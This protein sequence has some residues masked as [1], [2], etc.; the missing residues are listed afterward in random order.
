MKRRLLTVA[1]CLLA[2]CGPNPKAP[3]KVMALAPNAVGQFVVTQVE[4]QTITDVTALKGQVASLVGGVSVVVD[5]N[6]PLQQI[7]GGFENQTDAQRYAGIV[8]NTG[9]DV[10]GNFIDKAGVLW[11]A[12][13]NTWDMVTTYYNFERSYLY[14][15]SVYD[16]ADPVELRGLRVMYWPEVRVNS[17]EPL[18]DNAQY[19]SYIKSFVV[20]PSEVLQAVPLSMNVGVIGHEM[21]HR[22]FSVKV[23]KDVGVPQALVLWNNQPFN[24]LKSIDE[25]FAD[26]H[27]FGVTCGEPADCQPNFLAASITNPASIAIRDMSRPDACLDL[28]LKGALTSY[29]SSQWV[30]D[31][32]LYKYGGLWAAAL[33]QA[34]FSAGKI[35]TLQK[36]LVASYNDEDPNKTGLRQLIDGNLNQPTDTFTPEAVANVILAHITDPDLKKQT[37][38]QF[39]TRLQLKCTTGTGGPGLCAEIPNCPFTATRDSKICPTLPQ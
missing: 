36:A 14:Y 17:A 8:K 19:L 33:Y 18:T 21:A 39:L 34:G 11:P 3:V 27:G 30:R 6:D 35:G 38:S 32:A 24:T 23:H 10:T 2:A 37:C 28:A 7:N 20:V 1:A 13:F 15:L 5:D 16:G 12:D 25:G 22:V 29:T 26:F 4:L 9:L 31:P